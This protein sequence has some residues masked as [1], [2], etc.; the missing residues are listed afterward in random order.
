MRPLYR[1]E[2]GRSGLYYTDMLEAARLDPTVDDVAF[3]EMALRM[4][5]LL[6]AEVPIPAELR[7][8]R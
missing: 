5:D 6:R 3:A 1:T 7:V 4:A 2:P 8:E